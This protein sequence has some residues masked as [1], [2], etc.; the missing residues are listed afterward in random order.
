MKKLL[1]LTIVSTF[2]SGAWANCEDPINYTEEVQCVYNET[3]IFKKQLNNIYTKLYNQTN[4]KQALE[5]AQK[6]WLNY[7]D[8]QCTDF[9]IAESGGTND[10]QRLYEVACQGELTKTRIIY[11]KS[12]MIN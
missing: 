5:N 2:S 3:A 1:L 11:L 4:S 10:S 8:K 9:G 12:I 6:A 7:R